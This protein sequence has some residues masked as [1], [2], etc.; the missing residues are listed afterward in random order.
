MANLTL[1]TLYLEL[2]LTGAHPDNWIEGEEHVLTPYRKVRVFRPLFGAYFKK[3]LKVYSVDSNDVRAELTY[4]TQYQCVEFFSRTTQQCGKEVYGAILIVDETLPEKIELDYR[5]LGGPDNANYKA[6]VQSL[7]D[8]IRAGEEIDWDN[9]LDRP[10]RFQP[11]PHLHDALDLYGLEYLRDIINQLSE[12]IE[13]APNTQR[14]L[15]LIYHAN[16]REQGHQVLDTLVQTV[17][18]HLRSFGAQ[19]SEDKDSIGLSDVENRSFRDEDGVEGY[20][21]PSRS[22]NMVNRTVGNKVRTH[23]ALK[24]NPHSTHKSQIEGLQNVENLPIHTGYNSAGIGGLNVTYGLGSELVYVG[25]YNLQR[26]TWDYTNSYSAGNIQIPVQLF[27][28]QVTQTLQQIDTTLQQF[29][30]QYVTLTPKIDLVLNNQQLVATRKN[31]TMLEERE[32][33]LLNHNSCY[34]QM[35]KQITLHRPTTNF[36]TKE[37]MWEVPTWLR[38]LKCWI[39]FSDE[40]TLV[41][42]QY[43]DEV[44]PRRIRAV[45]DKTEFGRVFEQTETSAQPMWQ[46]SQDA[47]V[48]AQPGIILNKVARFTTGTQGFRQVRGAQLKI[49]PTC[50]IV[51]LVRTGV[52]GSALYPLMKSPAQVNLTATDGVVI[53]GQMQRAFHLTTANNSSRL[54]SPPL[55]TQSSK[56]VL[57]VI[58]QNELNVNEGWIG[59]A[60]APNYTQY[61][62]GIDGTPSIAS[63]GLVVDQIGILKSSTNQSG[64]IAEILIYDQ[65]LS[66]REVQAIIDYMNRKWAHPVG[67]PLDLQFVQ[68]A[69][70]VHL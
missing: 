52:D 57:S 47:I 65:Q 27:S 67:L 53:H 43:V 5:A 69:F 22:K 24:N 21:S 56:C 1:P 41:L 18:S 51:M 19:H 2:D 20:A 66:L 31:N 54:Q 16:M 37:T 29:Q 8:V 17:R 39:D 48:P 59:T 34:A 63:D 42:G 68:T 35:L 6:I 38:G 40:S 25:P 32:Y 23:A 58:S 55:S 46:A 44:S 11:G 14:A 62:R 45:R 3:D 49:R 30:L 13:N 64:E 9:I 15:A 36:N 12:T 70:D 28:Q 7:V 61:P 33:R 4:G 10:R 60:Y 26:Y 50:T